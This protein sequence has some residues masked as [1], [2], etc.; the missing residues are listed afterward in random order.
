LIRVR[1]DIRLGGY[2]PIYP[3]DTS[4]L[5]GLQSFADLLT[6]ERDNFKGIAVVLRR[7]TMLDR[8]IRSALADKLDPPESYKQ[9]TFIWRRQHGRPLKFVTSDPIELAMKI[10]DLRV[11]ARHLRHADRLDPRVVSWLADQF[12]P[13]SEHNSHFRIKAARKD[14]LWDIALHN[15]LMRIGRDI[16]EQVQR[17]GMPL[18][19]ALYGAVAQEERRSR[20]L[21]HSKARR[22][23]DHY[24]RR[25]PFEILEFD[26]S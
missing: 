2:V 21:S 23:Y 18:K 10:G 1:V 3:I 15:E 12:A 19:S 17:R 13:A 6:V 11:V 4:G 8:S 9:S 22:A 14:R 26:R 16:C 5:Q 24:R 7:N 25:K 20:T